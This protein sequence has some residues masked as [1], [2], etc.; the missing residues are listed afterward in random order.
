MECPFSLYVSVWQI[1]LKWKK[2]NFVSGLHVDECYETN[3]DYVMPNTTTL[4]NDA[5]D[6]VVPC[7]LCKWGDF[8]AGSGELNKYVKEA[9]I[10]WSTKGAQ[11]KLPLHLHT[12]HIAS[13]Q[14]QVDQMIKDNFNKFQWQVT[15]ENY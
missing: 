1:I 6:D 9:F 7:Y 5:K 10:V 12:P 13:F 8:G 11:W 2:T 15:L 14:W 3:I 4:P